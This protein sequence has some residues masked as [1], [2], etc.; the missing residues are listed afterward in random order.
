MTFRLTTL[1]RPQFVLRLLVTFLAAVLLLFPI[2]KR[3]EGDTLCTGG[4]VNVV[5]HPDDDLLFLVR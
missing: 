4:T 3:T 1:A 5:A 2:G